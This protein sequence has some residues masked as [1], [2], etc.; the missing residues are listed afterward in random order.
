MITHDIDRKHEYCHIRLVA[1]LPTG[2]G[3]PVSFDTAESYGS[4]TGSASARGGPP[5]R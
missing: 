1:G 4:Q 2:K 5:S 3:S